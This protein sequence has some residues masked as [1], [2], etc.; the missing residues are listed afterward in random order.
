MDP[1]GWLSSTRPGAVLRYGQ[2]GY[3]EQRAYDGA[4]RLTQLTTWQAFDPP[5]SLRRPAQ[6][7]PM[8]LQPR[9]CARRQALQRW[10][11][12]CLHYAGG[13]LKTRT[14]GQAW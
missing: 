12:D 5:I 7:H 14:G 11:P 9:R 1:S 3:P 13:R 4:G 2:G 6:P 10:R 8:A